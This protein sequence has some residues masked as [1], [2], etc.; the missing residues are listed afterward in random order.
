[1]KTRSLVARLTATLTVTSALLFLSAG[2][3]IFIFQRVELQEHQT[4][5]LRARLDIIR[6][7]VEQASKSDRWVYLKEKLASFTPPDDSLRFIIQSSDSRLNFGTYWP[8]DATLNEYFDG[9]IYVHLAG[10]TFHAVETT[11]PGRDERPP[12]RVIV[13]I[14]CKPVELTRLKLGVGVLVVSLLATAIIGLLGRVIA[15]RGLTPLEALS[16]HAASLDPNDSSALLPDSGLPAELQEMT[17]AFNGALQRLHLA[18]A[19]LSTFNADVAHELRTPLANL[20]GQTQ[21]G[22]SR[23]RA[24]AELEDLLQSNLE[25]F[26][27]MQR[28]VNDMLFLAR[29]DGGMLAR[30]LAPTPIAALVTKTAELFEP[31]LED[32]G[33]KLSIHGDA[34]AMVEPSLLGRAL[35]N[36]IDNGI[37]HSSKPAHIDVNIRERADLIHIEVVNPAAPEVAAHLGRLFD[38]F[39]RIDPARQRTSAKNHGLGLAIAKAIAVMHGGSATARYGDGRVTIE[40]AL[41]R[42]NPG[43]G[44]P[45]PPAAITRSHGPSAAASAPAFP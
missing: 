35:A 32:A 42:Q 7:L 37:R 10:R 18:N 22:L 21:V 5:E 9:S 14:D 31:I 44:G 40:I 3:A 30:N 29:A 45:S 13:A 23:R 36:L 2:V 34:V 41:P 15:R 17:K 38:R 4:S 8:S 20:I 26:E 1:M 25:E 19:K 28:I 16:R 11:V 33:M 27:R 12:A 39:Y 24:L 43:N 6:P